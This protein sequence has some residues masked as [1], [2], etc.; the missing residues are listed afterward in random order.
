MPKSQHS[1]AQNRSLVG[2][3]PRDKA[4]F[5]LRKLLSLRICTWIN[6][7]TERDEAAR[8]ECDPW[9]AQASE[10]FPSP[11]LFWGQRADLQSGRGS[12]AGPALS[13]P[14]PA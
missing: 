5:L 10:V 8:E 9:N 2:E 7:D 14:G 12:V 11:H 3:E 1:W 13:S 4:C 6:K